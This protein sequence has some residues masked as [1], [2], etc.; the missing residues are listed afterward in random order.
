[1]SSHSAHVHDNKPPA[2]HHLLARFLHVFAA[3]SVMLS[4]ILLKI[5]EDIE[6]ASMPLDGSVGR[7]VRQAKLAKNNG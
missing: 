1:M 7:L 5:F 6:M 3:A 4:I 2:T